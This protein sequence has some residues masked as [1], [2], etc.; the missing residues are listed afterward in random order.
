MKIFFAIFFAMTILLT[1]CAKQEPPVEVTAQKVH[2]VD[3][4]LT[5]SHAGTIA[6]SDATE[7][8]SPLSGSVMEK[9]F[10][11]GATVTEEQVLFK[12]GVIDD[13]TELLQAKAELA[14]LRTDLAQALAA[15][16]P[17]ADELKLEVDEKQELVKQLDDAAKPGMVVSPKA[18]R[19]DATNTPLGM[20]VTADETVLATIGNVNPVSVRFDVSAQEARI[21]SATPDLT[22]RLKLSDGTTFD[23]TIKLSDDATTAQALFDNSD[24][25]LT[26]GTPAQIEIAG[27]KVASLLLVP[28]NAIQRREDGDFVFV[29]DSDKEAAAKKISLG[30]RLGTYFIVT[31]GLTPNDLVIVE[32]MTGLREGT[33][34]K[35]REKG[36]G[37][38]D[39]RTMD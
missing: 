19:I 4:T 27:A 23:G 29:V 31:N 33:P 13:H 14:K 18:G 3:G 26:P 15:R 10:A 21:L 2:S 5:L 35:L 30:D 6:L 16:D 7:I 25:A 24:E 32:G 11:E 34:L 37:T 38:R 17:S 39:K 28:E 36:E 8:R 12:I 22:A 1:G 20:K 9:F